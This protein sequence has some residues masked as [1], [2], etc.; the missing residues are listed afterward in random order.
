MATL[1]VRVYRARDLPVMDSRTH[2]T[3]GYVRVRYA[4]Q[5]QKTNTVSGSLS[6]VWEDPRTATMRFDVADEC[7]LPENPLEVQV[8]DHDR[9]TADDQIGSVFVDMNCILANERPAVIGWFPIFDTMHGLR[10]ELMLGVEIRFLGST[11]NPF[12]P[13]VPSAQQDTETQVQRKNVAIAAELESTLIFAVSMLDPSVYRVERVVGMIEELAV[14]SDPEFARLQSL[15]SSRTTNDQRVLEFYRIGG[16][17]RRNLTRKTLEHGCNAI[18]GFRVDYDVEPATGNFAVRAYGT[19]CQVSRTSADDGPELGADHAPKPTEELD[20]RD[21][22]DRSEL[23]AEGTR[24]KRHMRNLRHLMK[25]P[26]RFVTLRGVPANVCK[27]IGGVVSARSIK[28]VTHQKLRAAEQERD[29]WWQEVREEIKLNAMSFGCNAVIAYE[30]TA[31]F[32]EDICIL[33]ASGT[34]VVADFNAYQWSQSRQLRA[35]RL[36]RKPTRTS[37]KGEA[38]HITHMPV[39]DPSEL[40]FELGDGMDKCSWCKKPVSRMLIANMEIP[41]DLPITNEVPTGLVEARYAR[42]KEKTGGEQLAVSVSK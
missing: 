28:L 9:W 39:R 23:P 5:T 35:Q 15:R 7:D 4:D 1:M 36:K 13:F 21:R 16:R 25:E 22:P 6:P 30:E 37:Q 11:V 17:V 41:P 3:D 29:A 8:W 24:H 42:R 38:C 20:P 10:G 27:R 12:L 33:S 34:A 18:L 19:C 26:T 40:P 32:H 2:L 31:E 14:A